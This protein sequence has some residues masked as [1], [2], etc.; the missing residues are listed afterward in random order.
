MVGG[1]VPSAPRFKSLITP[2]FDSRLRL[3]RRLAARLFSVPLCLRFWL[4]MPR[5]NVIILSVE[6]SYCKLLIER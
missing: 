1:G 6:M 5:R 2:L 3:F 4:V